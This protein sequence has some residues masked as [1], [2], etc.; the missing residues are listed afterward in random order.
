MKPFLALL[1][2]LFS[3]LLTFTQEL[4]VNGDFEENSGC[5][6][7]FSSSGY[8]S[9]ISGSDTEHDFMRLVAPWY[10]PTSGTSDLI[11]ACSTSSLT[12][13]P[14]N[15]WGNSLPSSGDG[16]AAIICYHNMDLDWSPIP[17]GVDYTE[18]IQAE[19]SE[20]LI[21]GA[22]YS[23]SFKIKLAENS[24]FAI[25]QIGM[26]LHVGNR[27][28]DDSIYAG[29]LDLPPTLLTPVGNLITNT[30]SWATIEAEFTASNAADHITIGR[31]AKAEELSIFERIEQVLPVNLRRA[32]YF[33]DEVSVELIS[34]PISIEERTAS[35]LK[36]VSLGEKRFNIYSSSAMPIQVLNLHG[37]VV[38]QFQLDAGQNSITLNGLSSGLY[39]LKASSGEAYKLYLN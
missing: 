25:D 21:P 26:S 14:L 37:S 10:C 32:I 7:G 9:F 16:Y 3:S 12:A 36:I 39:I 20:P 33:I 27:V 19:L 23:A 6:T 17:T 2:L 13:V 34:I 4:V 29:R 35:S 38:S 5:P 31:F 1:F 15:F 28:A 8:F 18:Y 30:A 22:I 24:R 11:H